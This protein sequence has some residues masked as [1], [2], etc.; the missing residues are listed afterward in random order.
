MEGNGGL[1]SSLG[2]AEWERD[3]QEKW[4]VCASG[5]GTEPRV[6]VLPGAVSLGSS[7]PRLGLP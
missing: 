3:A 1:Q 2:L 6:A 7:S 5:R 4:E